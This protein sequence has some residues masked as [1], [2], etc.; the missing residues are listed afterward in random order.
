MP[1]PTHPGQAA[2]SHL[3]ASSPAFSENSAS[4][5]S[6][7][8]GCA[9]CR[10]Q[11]AGAG[12]GRESWGLLALGLGHRAFMAPDAFEAAFALL[13]MPSSDLCYAGI[14]FIRPPGEPIV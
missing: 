9:H 11:C 12:V 13:S 3:H 2:L 5:L 4:T 10:R 6:N 14:I 8:P 7:R 1:A